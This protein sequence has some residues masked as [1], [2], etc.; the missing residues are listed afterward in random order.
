MIRFVSLFAMLV[1]ALGRRSAFAAWSLLAVL[2]LAPSR[3]DAQQ[4]APAATPRLPELPGVLG[5][6]TPSFSI[7]PRA[8]F[9]R[10]GP[11]GARMRDSYASVWLSTNV[12]DLLPASAAR[13]WPSPVRLSV[14]RRALSGPL[15]A[16]YAV[17]LD[18]DAA[19]LPGSHP[20]WMAVKQVLHTV[21]LPGPALVVSP[22][23]TRLL[24]LYW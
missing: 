6:V 2:L 16:E 4:D 8:V 14:G 17:G 7:A 22:T 1:R 21:R 23:G 13:A 11:R 20:A 15:G 5:T 24:G 18:L 9:V 12:H 19:R 10:R 3:A